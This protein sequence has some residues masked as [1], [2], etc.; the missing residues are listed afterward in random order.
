MRAREF[1]DD[2]FAKPLGSVP[3]VP[4]A[5]ATKRGPERKSQP[6]LAAR[7]NAVQPHKPVKP[8]SPVQPVASHHNNVQKS[9]SGQRKPKLG[10]S[11]KRA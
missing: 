4:C 10:P 8:K 9:M 5:C 3:N 1:L 2:N 6:S 11:A 7:K